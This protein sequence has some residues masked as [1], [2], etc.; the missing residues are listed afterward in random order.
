MLNVFYRTHGGITFLKKLCKN[1]LTG[2]FLDDILI[3]LSPRGTAQRTLKNEQ[4]SRENELNP[5][6]HLSKFQKS[7]VSDDEAWGK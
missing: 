5:C 4:H 6:I 1:L 3:K 2:D 7:K